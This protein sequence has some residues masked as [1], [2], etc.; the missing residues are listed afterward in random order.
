MFIYVYFRNSTNFDDMLEE[1]IQNILND[2]CI[3]S[4]NVLKTAKDDLDTVDSNIKI[5][6]ESPELDEEFHD[7]LFLEEEV[8]KNDTII[9]KEKNDF[10][11]ENITKKKEVN[12]RKKKKIKPNI[13]KKTLDMKTS[14]TMSIYFNKSCYFGPHILKKKLA[15]LPNSIGPGPVSTILQQ[16]INIFINLDY[17]PSTTLKKIKKLQN[18]LFN[19]PGGIE[20]LVC[21]K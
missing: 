11:K 9:T 2:N 15:K 8:D 14:C 1:S 16:A 6:I 18:T 17:F 21:S 3:A 13:H 20:M 10:I 19:G 5:K 12:V 7:A 4:S